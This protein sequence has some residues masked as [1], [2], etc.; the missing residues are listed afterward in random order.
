LTD[1]ALADACLYFGRTL[2]LLDRFEPALD[3]LRRAIER[4]PQNAQLHR[5]AALSSEGA[6][7]TED[8]EAAF[9][10]AMRLKSVGVPDED[11]SIDY[12]VF[13]FRQGRAAE[14]LAPLEDAAKRLPRASRAHLELGCVLLAVDR[15]PEAAAELE[16]AVAI[17]SRLQRAHLLLGKAYLR[18]GKADLAQQHL[19]LGSRTVK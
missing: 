6:G 13:L 9:R 2:Y 18:M 17:D 11:P 3:V 10:Q 8:A 19:Q 5:I 16:R 12:G 1:P 4:D 15:V 14:A 7:R